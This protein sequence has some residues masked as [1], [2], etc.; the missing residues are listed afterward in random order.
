MKIQA[1]SS[2]LTLI[3]AGL[4][5]V[6][7][8]ACV[9]TSSAQ[10]ASDAVVKATQYS[11]GASNFTATM[12]YDPNITKGKEVQF[13]FNVSRKVTSPSDRP[14]KYNLFAF[15]VESAPGT[16]TNIIDIS[17]IPQTKVFFTE[18]YFKQNIYCAGKY[19]LVF[20]VQEYT[21]NGDGTTSF[22]PYTRFE[23]IFTVN[24]N[25]SLKTIPTIVD[26]IANQCVQETSAKGD[27]SQWAKAL[28]LHDWILNN[29]AYD[30]SYYYMGPEGSLARGLSTCE[31]Y[32]AGYALLLNKLDIE[33]R[34][35]D[36]PK[37]NH[38]WTGAK[39]DGQWYNIDTT[40]DDK[41]DTFQG[42]D[43]RHLYFAVPN[44]IMLMA[45]KNWDGKFALRYEGNTRVGADFEATDFSKTYLFKTGVISKF[46]EPYLAASGTYSVSAKIN[47]QR[48]FTLQAAESFPPATSSPWPP[49][50]INNVYSQ[51]AY[52]LSQ[53]YSDGRYQVAYE[54][55]VE[56]SNVNWS[57]G[58]IKFEVSL[59]S[60]TI[61]S[62]PSET[63]T[64]QGV[65]PTPSRVQL[66]AITLKEN[67]YILEYENNINA[68]IN[69]QKAYV[70]VKGINGYTGE[71]RLEFQINP[72]DLSKATIEAPGYPWSEFTYNGNEHKPTPQVFYGSLRTPV[73][74]QC[75]TYLYD[76]NRYV[77]APGNP[78]KITV[79]GRGDGNC[80][81]EGSTTFT[82]I[83]K[84]IKYLRVEAPDVNYD[85]TEKRPVKVWDGS[86][87]LLETVDYD[88]TYISNQNVGTATATIRGK[89]NYKDEQTAT[90]TIKSVQTGG[91]GSSGGTGT[92]GT[93]GTN[94]QPAYPSLPS[95]ESTN[96]QSA[97]NNQQAAQTSSAPPAVIGT[98]KKSKGRWWFQYSGA[99][100][101]AMGA[102]QQ[103]PI[104]QWLTISGKRYYFDGAGYM[105][106]GWKS[107]GGNWYFFGSDG[108]MRINWAKSGGK[109]YYFNIDGVMQTGK[110]NVD[111]ATY[112]LKS[113]GA[114]ATGWV[115]YEG[116][117]RYC[118]GS[119][120]M[121]TG[122]KK[123]GGKWYYLNPGDGV[124]LTDWQTIDG[125][126]YYFNGSGAM[127]AK[128]WI[129]NSYV[130]PSGAMVTN[131]WVGKY[132]VD[133]NGVWDQ[134]R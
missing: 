5:V 58:Q 31:S 93:G 32:H 91:S 42:I 22:G 53:K 120:A 122:W 83:P 48:P 17:R 73:S 104:N 69:G 51:V 92:G 63:F 82:I 35:V 119:G 55:C 4:L 115:T 101:N 26:E 19:R 96:N 100:Q 56:Y 90:F 68:T 40:W 34:R 70:I 47:T 25:G 114:M 110:I 37:D 15:Q 67:D 29:T 33:T 86:Q 123:L 66:G 38:V 118:S 130:G 108:A 98:W 79:K 57:N 14:L 72:L 45:H 94:N 2:K 133:A 105:V 43:I 62:I 49:S 7:A 126:R 132:H 52:Q 46:T 107:L 60:A 102:P 3:L 97:T 81:G 125:A 71:K 117:W 16:W 8:A 87:Q 77:S 75:L 74:A 76:N 50:Y 113:S 20:Q 121:Q 78:A 23:T 131:A 64:G 10:A 85:G 99:S 124:M 112:I 9:P 21:D 24:E 80:I 109:W 116:T 128:K 106:S 41:E 30:S 65:K 11:T 54:P 13:N 36:S 59:A 61:S 88:I 12:S 18:S 27:T 84:S 103:Y 89:G 111:G 1:L 44:S 127:Q 129:G 39:L 95:V 28:W 134:T 6:L